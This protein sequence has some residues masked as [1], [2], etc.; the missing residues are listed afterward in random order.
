MFLLATVPPP[1]RGVVRRLVAY[2]ETST[3]PLRRRQAPTPTCTLVLGLGEPLRVD[4]R[5]L[6]SFLDGLSDAAAVTEFRGHQA[7]VQVD[8]APLGLLRLLGAPGREVTGAPVVA[9]DLAALS[10]AG[11]ALAALPA[12]LGELPDPGARLALVT[13]TLTDLLADSVAAPDPEVAH[14][15]R[16]LE[17]A[18]GR[19]PLPALAAEVGWSRRH[20]SR[21]FAA[22]VGLAPTTTA[23]VLRFR[24]A[25][26]LLVPRPGEPAGPARRIA[27]VAQTAG[28]ADHAH[29]DREFRALAGCTPQDYVAGWAT[30]GVDP[31]EV[32]HG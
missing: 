1:L 6:G 18:G 32:V 15:W 26:D 24:C 13:A 29:L 17:H 10:P 31:R 27:D 25:A 2:D 20:L 9:D 8:L 30:A 5:A 22:Q 3:E 11:A 12:R 7:G 19:V 14:A 4:G 28:Y 23:R 16:R 21:R